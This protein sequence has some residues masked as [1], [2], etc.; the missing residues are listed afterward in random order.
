MGMPKGCLLQNMPCNV[1]FGCFSKFKQGRDF[2]T[3]GLI[4]VKPMLEEHPSEYCCMG[5]PSPSKTLKSLVDWLDKE[6]ERRGYQVKEK[7]L[8][9]LQ[10]YVDSVNYNMLCGIF[11][12][13]WCCF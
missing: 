9:A 6:S 4:P 2:I 12:S 5:N 11:K 8:L 10:V 13:M 7:Y 1:Q 3:R